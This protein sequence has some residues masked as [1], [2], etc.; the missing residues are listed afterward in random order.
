MSS[1][2]LSCW[3]IYAAFFGRGGGVLSSLDP[4]CWFI[5]FG[6]YFHV[7]N[8]YILCQIMTNFPLVWLCVPP[9]TLEASKGHC[10]RKAKIRLQQN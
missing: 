7:Y 6:F 8:I 2:H 3:V 10:S 4:K 1:V 5:F 9:D